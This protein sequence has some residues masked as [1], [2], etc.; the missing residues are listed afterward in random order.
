MRITYDD[1]GQVVTAPSTAYALDA[2][3]GTVTLLEDAEPTARVPLGIDLDISYIPGPIE[4]SSKDPRVARGQQAV[5]VSVPSSARPLAPQV[6]QILPAFT[7]GNPGGSNKSERSGGTLRLYLARPWFS[8]GI[9]ED[10]AIVLLPSGRREV[11]EARDA[12]VTQWGQDPVVKSG[13]LPS[14]GHPGFPTRTD[15]EGGTFTQGV[16]LAEVDAPVDVLRFRVGSYN[17]EGVVTGYDDERDMWFVDIT[18][19]P[20]AAYRPFV[21]LA[22]ARYQ[23]ASVGGLKLSPVTLVDVVQLEPN[24]N[25]GVA[26][27]APSRGAAKTSASVTLSGPS[28]VSNA[29]GPGPGRVYA[30]LEKYEGPTGPKVVPSAM[31]AWTEIQRVTLRGSVTNSGAATW[32]GSI[33]VPATRPS[34]TYRIVLEEYEL[35]RI[36][37]SAAPLPQD[38]AARAQLL[39]ERLVHQDI[40]GI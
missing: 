33:P 9:D 27:R 25:A 22:L 31:A 2:E 24:R 34:G 29:V 23:D 38:Q 14:S 35:H 40:I 19:K 3:S 17:A 32:T 30:I 16:R 18:M 37:G 11:V 6:E 12:L 13:G 1:G 20:G 26:V 21:R 5:R 7:W 36:D 10:L 4:R 8:S 28:Y 15:F 39:G